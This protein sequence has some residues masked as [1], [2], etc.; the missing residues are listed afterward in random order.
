MSEPNFT[1]NKAASDLA[2]LMAAMNRGEPLPQSREMD[3]R[4][5]WA[6]EIAEPMRAADVEIWAKRLGLQMDLSTF[7][8]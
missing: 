2:S 4:C 6:V 3:E 1:I 5:G 8:D 7:G